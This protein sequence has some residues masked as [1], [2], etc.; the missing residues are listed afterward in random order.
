MRITAALI[1]VLAFYTCKESNSHSTKSTQWTFKGA[2]YKADTT[3]FHDNGLEGEDSLENSITV[4]FI[5]KPVTD[6]TYKVI[7][8]SS[9]PD[10]MANTCSIWMHD[11][12][13]GIGGYYALGKPGDKVNVKINN[14]KI[15]ASF[16]NITVECFDTA[17]KK[18]ETVSGTLIEQ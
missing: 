13:M 5:K 15:V 8:F 18:I 9:Y 1:L 7:S 17:I 3:T 2:N 12:K 14:G 10:S 6:R 16:V 4:M 11:P